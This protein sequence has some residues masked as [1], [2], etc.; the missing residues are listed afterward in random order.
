[1]NKKDEQLSTPYQ[2]S[3]PKGRKTGCDKIWCLTEGPEKQ[4]IFAQCRT[5][6]FHSIVAL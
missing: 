4:I 6:L 5:I 1:M 3:L 2:S